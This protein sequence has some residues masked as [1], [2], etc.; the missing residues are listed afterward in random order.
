[1]NNVVYERIGRVLFKKDNIGS[2]CNYIKEFEDSC[3]TIILITDTEIDFVERGW[4]GDLTYWA[5]H[6]FDIKDYE[7]ED[8]TSEPVCVRD[9]L[10]IRVEVKKSEPDCPVEW[11][12][13]FLKY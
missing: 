10:C 5:T 1:M 3:D 8:L 6:G 7:K 4:L 12:Y 13:T 9:V 11:K 2:N